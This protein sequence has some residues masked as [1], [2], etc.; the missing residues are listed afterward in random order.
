VYAAALN[1]PDTLLIEGK[2]QWEHPF[3][4]IP[5]SEAGGTIK[6]LGAN[7][8]G[9]DKGDRVMATPGIGAM[10]EQV[11]VTVSS[12]RKIP[13]SMSFQTASGFPMFYTISYYAL[14]QRANLKPGETLLVLGA[15]GGVGVTA[16]EL[17][18]LMGAQVI[19]GASSEEKLQFAKKASADLLFN[20]SDGDL[21]TKIKELTKGK[22]ADVIYDPVGGDLFD[23]ATRCINWNGRLLVVGFASGRIPEYKANLALL[24][25]ASMIGVFM[26]R[27]ATEEPEAYETNMDELFEF[28]KQGKIKPAVNQSF[29]MHDFVSAFNIFKERKAMGK[30]TLEVKK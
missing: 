5:G 17:G 25:G 14:K 8:K 12:L 26:G 28:F 6:E 21:K 13:E 20:Y 4:F 9:F 3:P 29:K 11:C 2:Y 23:Q 1:S 19:A 24:K 7:V 10:A 22:G 18:K 27:F 30:V 15:S 16:V